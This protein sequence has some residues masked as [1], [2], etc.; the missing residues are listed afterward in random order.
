MIPVESIPGM[1]QE[2][3]RENGG[4]GESK[5]VIFDTL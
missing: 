1:G 5:Y 4:G 3:M 2:G